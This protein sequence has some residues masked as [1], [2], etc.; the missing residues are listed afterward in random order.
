M[1]GLVEV[2]AAEELAGMVR[3]VLRWAKVE[4][5]EDKEVMVA[6]GVKVERGEWRLVFG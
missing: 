6:L 1:G 5:R 2:E 3:Q 4:A